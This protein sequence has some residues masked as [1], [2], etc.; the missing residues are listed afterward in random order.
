MTDPRPRPV[1]TPRAMLGRTVEL[2]RAR[3]RTWWGIA[4]AVV[5][6]F[7]AVVVGVAL[8]AP[9]PT[10][11]RNPLQLLAI[12]G[13]FLLVSPL[14]VGAISL[15]VAPGQGDAGRGARPA[16]A[17]TLGRWGPLAGA[18]LLYGIAVAGGLVLLIVPGIWMLFAL[19]FTPQAVML[20]GASW[21]A[22]PRRSFALVRG[23]FGY[24]ARMTLTVLVVVA[25][26][27]VLMQLLL[28]PLTA[29]LSAHA[30]TAALLA[31]GVPVDIVLAPVPA[32]A[33]TL[34]YLELRR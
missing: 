12:T 15:C 14:L 25:G 1:L 5:V 30:E 32:I 19:Q 23:R 31:V 22:A 6:P 17:R 29:G 4:A 27:G 11:A 20:D 28:A 26:L 10:A 3:W 24:V 21:R 13:D 2:Y 8:A 18:A 16:L 9:D 7:Q 33:L 34:V